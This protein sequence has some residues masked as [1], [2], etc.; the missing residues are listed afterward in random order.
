M[1]QETI[2][3]S[4][5]TFGFQQDQ[6]LFKQL[7]LSIPQ[8]T[9][10]L[11]HGPS[12]CG[13]STLLKLLA[14]LLPEFGGH[15]Y[16]GKIARNYQNWG[17]V[18]QNPERQFTMATPRQ[19][20]IFTLEN[21][22][23]DWKTAQSRISYAVK[24]TEIQNLL[25][26]KFIQLSGG[27]K[28]RVAFAIILAM[29]PDLVLLDEPF[30]SCDQHTREFLLQKLTAMKQQHLTIV[31]SDHNLAGYQDLCDE[32]LEFPPNAPIQLLTST[33]KEKIFS[34]KETHSLSFKIPAS[35][36]P[37]LIQGK[38]CS[39]KQG[40]KILID[41]ANFQIFAHTAT[42]LSGD[43]GSGKTSL[44][45]A[46]TKL[47]E[48]QGSLTY[49]KQEIKR[50]KARD[51]LTHVSQVFQNAD[52]QFIMVTVGEELALSQKYAQNPV[53]KG[54]KLDRVLTL[55]GLAEKSQ[56]VVYSL[57]GGQKKKLQILL[58][59]LANPDVLLLDEPFAG[60]DQQSR[61]TIYHLLQE[62]YLKLGKTAIIISHQTQDLD[63]LCCY[64]L[65]L[66]NQQLTYAQ[67]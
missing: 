1:S 32:F 38:D 9:F 21:L 57:S 54:E 47:L 23:L 34:K 37:V 61:K 4:D 62:Y 36:Q 12:G 16:Q 19:E 55:L 52:D 3:I 28:Q 59:L 27:E 49:Q 25:D 2:K 51:Y 48:Y 18:F 13:K 66:Q 46:L 58:M 6:P 39:L 41:H 35:D 15:I 40:S 63:Q 29:Q 65:K 14:D 50:L 44:F 56:Q 30:A 42:F 43:N 26:Q 5:L 10:M 24:E 11:L 33:E 67:D 60:L 8:G 53:L 45:K 17:M 64:H 7:N 20:F 22:K 31:I